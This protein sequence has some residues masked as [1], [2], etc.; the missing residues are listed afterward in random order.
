MSQL[1][2]SEA[3][4]QARRKQTCQE[5]FLAEMENL[6]PWKELASTISCFYSISMNRRKAEPL[7][8]IQHILC[9]LFF[10]IRTI[11]FV[12]GFAYLVRCK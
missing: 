9:M 4:G 3:E 11:I 1:S 2:Y 5:N 10:K 8:A 12:A 6:L 7:S